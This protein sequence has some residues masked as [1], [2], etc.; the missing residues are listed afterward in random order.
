MIHHFILPLP[1]LRLVDYYNLLLTLCGEGKK[2][3]FLIYVSL[4]QSEDICSL[5]SVVGSL[6]VETSLRVSAL[7]QLSS[8][9]KGL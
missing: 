1:V 4:I 8:I 6:K 7:D 3:H 9:L 2:T 5:L